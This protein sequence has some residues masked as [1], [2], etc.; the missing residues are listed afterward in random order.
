MHPSNDSFQK[1]VQ[2]PSTV[3]CASVPLDLLKTGQLLIVR[4]N[5][6]G[7]LIIQKRFYADF[8][9]PGAAVGG[10][11]DVS[12]TSVYAIGNVEFYAPT[13][14]EERQQAFQKRIAYAQTLGEVLQE[15]APLRRAFLIINQLS[16]W[17]GA[18]KT[19]RIPPEL[20]AH[21]GGLLPRTVAVAL[22]QYSTGNNRQVSEGQRT[23]C[24]E[25]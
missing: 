6:Q 12:C 16:Q 2:I 8:V 4:P 9:G 1:T 23:L 25:R 17:V 13:T 20:I 21:L 19:K 11:F 24:L 18:D 14:Y 15:L 7:G 5:C 10:S 3:P 22:R